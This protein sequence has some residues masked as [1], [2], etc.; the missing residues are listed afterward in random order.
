MLALSMEDKK[1]SLCE[2]YALEPRAAEDEKITC[3]WIFNKFYYYCGS[4]VVV[5]V[6]RVIEHKNRVV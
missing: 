6:V 3:N 4:V 1:P 5:V 2:Y